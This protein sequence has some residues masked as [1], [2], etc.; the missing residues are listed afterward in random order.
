[1]STRR[2]YHPHITLVTQ[3][4]TQDAIEAEEQLQSLNLDLSFDCS[5]ICLYAKQKSWPEWKVLV[6]SPLPIAK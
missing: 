4:P 6:E 3:I 1:M 2:S 5:K